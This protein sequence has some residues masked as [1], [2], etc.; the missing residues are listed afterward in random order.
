MILLS[1]VGSI[2]A[3]EIKNRP[4]GQFCTVDF[5]KSSAYT[6]LAAQSV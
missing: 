1:V 4:S 2:G 6:N 3:R 5:F